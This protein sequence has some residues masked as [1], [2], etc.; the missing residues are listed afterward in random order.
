MI[1]RRRSPRID[2]QPDETIR[3]TV[4]H[5]VQLLDISLSGALVACEA[6]LPKGTRGQFRTA[7]AGTPFTAEVMVQRHDGRVAPSQIGLGATFAS[8]D[9]QNRRSLEQFLRRGSN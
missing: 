3:V 7:L 4:R 6:R 9:D 1:E 8:L 5:R 2:I